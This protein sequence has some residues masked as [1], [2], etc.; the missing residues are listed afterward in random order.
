MPVTHIKQHLLAMLIACHAVLFAGCA[1]TPSPQSPEQAK[2]A[3]NIGPYP[4]F[5]GRLIVIEPNRRWQTLI[6]WQ[7]PDK[8]HG[9]LRLTHAASN[10]V[11]E[12]TWQGNNMQLRDNR[13]HE[14]RPLTLQQ[15]A[16]HGIVIPPARLASI[17]LGNMPPG[18][19][20]KSPNRWESSV[21]GTRI[22]LQWQPETNRLTMI[23]SKH[24]RQA[25]L[26]IQP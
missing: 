6:D 21:A 18:F 13:H 16:E 5:S 15:L 3:D 17:L 1:T 24:G 4:A 19:R 20:S 23:D 10:T 8:N 25:T 11:V 7:A 2:Q 14:W 22:Q 9:S 12:F 26:V